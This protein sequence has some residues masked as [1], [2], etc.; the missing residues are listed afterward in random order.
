M[1]DLTDRVAEQQVPDNAT[2][3]LFCGYSL[4]KKWH[5]PDYTKIETFCS[6]LAA[7]TQRKLANV[8]SQQAVKL[9]YANPELIMTFFLNG[10]AEW[11]YGK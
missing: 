3:R 5:A 2:F 9:G 6:R 10:M 8:M 1:F 7:G 11:F 4:L